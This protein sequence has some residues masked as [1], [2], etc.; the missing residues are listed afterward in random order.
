MSALDL[1][2]D[3]FDFSALADSPTPATT[4]RP[5]L[6]NVDHCIVTM[7]GGKDSLAALLYLLEQ[8][9]PR[10]RIELHHHLVD[11]KASNFLDWPITEAYCEALAQAFGLQITFSWRRGGLL[12][13]MLRE[14]APTAPMVVP[15]PDGNGY[16]EVGGKGPLGTRRKF[17]QLS[18]DLRLRWCSSSA[19]IS[20]LDA[21]LR[22]HPKFR[23]KRTLVITGERAEES[24]NRA[25]YATFEPHRADTRNS[26]RVP[27]HID[28]WRPVHMWSEARVWEIIARWR[29]Q[30]HP[31]YIL[32][33]GRV[34]C[35]LCIYGSKH[36]WA[37]ARAIDRQQ[38]DRVAAYE[39]EFKVTIHRKKTVVE[40]ADSGTPYPLDPKWV[41]VA[42]GTTWDLPIFVDNW[43]MPA[44]AFGEASGPT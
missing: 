12:A 17:P 26:T 5:D 3:G 23:G 24:P 31:A 7:S 10:E 30:P 32:G 16:I 22:N 21:Y 8:G 15:A 2:S 28:H 34:S 37:S 18:P 44:G 27:R 33:W 11:G 1:E 13:E 20:L 39:R 6:S 29:V 4:L 35:R 14:N 36:Q 40:Q 9:F 42:N 43:S 38:F 19:K 41:A 25:H